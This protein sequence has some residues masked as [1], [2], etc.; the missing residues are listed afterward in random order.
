VREAAGPV[1]AALAELQRRIPT[2]PS[3]S[4]ASRYDNLVEVLNQSGVTL[5]GDVRAVATELEARTSGN[6]FYV[7]QLVLDAHST[8]RT[9]DAAVVPDA[10]AQLVARR[11]DAL[12]RDLSST[13][14][15]A[16]IAGPE[17]DLATIEACSSLPPERLLDLVEALCRQR[18]LF[19][20]DAE[21]FAFAHALVRDA[22]LATIG[23]TRRQR[24]HKR[25]A[26]ALARS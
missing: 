1:A 9:F 10:V 25:L 21:R 19:E 14:A 17:F 5:A 20:L 6:P 24:L 26:D 2:I 11:F 7:T 23:P 12:D 15:L 4:R 3:A 22:V 18:F 13:L 8:R 16:A